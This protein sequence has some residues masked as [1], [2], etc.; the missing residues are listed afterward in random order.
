MW[1]RGYGVSGN[2]C[3]T[4]RGKEFSRWRRIVKAVRPKQTPPVRW[5]PR[6]GAQSGAGGEGEGG[7]CERVGRGGGWGRT[8]LRGIRRFRA[9]RA[10]QAP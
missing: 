9:G 2:G 1:T 6:P 8:P 10:D 7:E 4:A 3:G 5:E